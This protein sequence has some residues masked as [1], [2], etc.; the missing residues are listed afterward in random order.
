M[1]SDKTYSTD[2]TCGTDTYH[3]DMIKL[4]L[5]KNTEKQLVKIN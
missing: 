3:M 5:L 1:W 4:R 2:E